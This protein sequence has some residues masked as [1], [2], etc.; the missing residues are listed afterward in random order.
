MHDIVPGGL[1]KWRPQTELVRGGLA[2][3]PFDETSEAMFVTSGYIYPTAEEAEA[4]FK[5]DISRYQYSRY[6]NPTVTMFEERLRLLEGAEHCQTTASGMAAVFASL[7]CQLRAG[8][9]VVASRALFGSSHFIITELLPRYGIETQFV[10]GTDLNAWAE[11]LSKPARCVLLETPSNP[12]LDIIDMA[13]VS[14]LAH[15]AGA[16]VI[17][18]NVFSTP[19]L[20]R[21]LRFG[22]DVVVYS[23]TKHIDGQGRTM[24]G[25]V[26]SSEAFFKDHLQG[27]VRHTGP[28]MSPFNAW[29][30]LKGL[31]TL[32][33]RVARHCDNAE[34]LATFLERQPG[35][36]RVLYPGLDSHPQAALARRQMSGR[37]STLITIEVEGGK[38][39]AFRLLNGLRIVDIANN[40][41]DS[42]SLV[43]HP[44]TTTHQRLAAEERA[45]IGITE[46]MVR[47]SVGLEDV[48]DLKDDFARALRV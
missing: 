43:C 41:G 10:D 36:A 44:A 1:T 13:A 34:A 38:A 31:E 25:A 35:I 7:L 15:A 19:I 4:A 32:E 28:C 16:T 33:L 40:L 30:L 20:Q 37:G 45:R 42:K 39:R 24:G 21:P 3:S 18:D 48:E 9:R 12:T 23:T 5:G 8:E 22:A 26:L 2:R 17:V 11:A 46:G 47:I 14:D 29:V 6:A 27:F